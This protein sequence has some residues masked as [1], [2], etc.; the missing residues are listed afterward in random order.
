MTT[1]QERQRAAMTCIPARPWS[2]WSGYTLRFCAE[3]VGG[4]K[5]LHL[6]LKHGK[7]DPAFVE[8]LQIFLEL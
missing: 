8:A 3:Q 5:Y 7:D 1:D 2:I 4:I 6:R